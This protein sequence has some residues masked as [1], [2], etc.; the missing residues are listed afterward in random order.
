MFHRLGYL[1]ITQKF[2]QKKSMCS[3]SK[4]K[5]IHLKNQT[6]QKPNRK[7]NIKPIV[8][9]QQASKWQAK[10]LRETEFIRYSILKMSD[11]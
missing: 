8:L 3:T 6:K 2:T 10:F 7:H 4:C 1:P 11:L 5:N 9:K